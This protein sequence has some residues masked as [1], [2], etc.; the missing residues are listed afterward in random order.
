[1]MKMYEKE[2]MTSLHG[3]CLCLQKNA[4]Y[5][6]STHLGTWA[7]RNKRDYEEGYKSY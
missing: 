6:T 3:G 2:N 5:C 4:M 1:M 7:Y